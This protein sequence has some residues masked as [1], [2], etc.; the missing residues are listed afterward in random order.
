MEEERSARREYNLIKMSIKPQ[1]RQR[2]RGVHNRNEKTSREPF[3]AGDPCPVRQAPSTH[4]LK[5]SP[6]VPRCPFEPRPPPP[7]TC[8]APRRATPQTPEG[9]QLLKIKLVDRGQFNF[10]ANLHP[11]S[12]GREEGEVDDDESKVEKFCLTR[13]YPSF[14]AV[15]LHDAR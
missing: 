5:A 13:P 2:R 12:G 11:G 4:A 8:A 14:I 3:L 6:T 10:L 9:S 1:Q 15:A 7:Q